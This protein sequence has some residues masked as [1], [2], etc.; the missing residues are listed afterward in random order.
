MRTEIS[1]SEESIGFVRQKVKNN[2]ALLYF[3]G[4]L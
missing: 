2:I 4:A 3:Q 1:G